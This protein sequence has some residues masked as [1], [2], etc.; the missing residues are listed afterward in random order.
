MPNQKNLERLNKLLEA[1]DSGAVLPEELI[2]AIDA[3]MAIINQNGRTLVDKIV[4]TKKASDSDITNLKSEL[5]KTRDNLQSVINQV[6]SN[7]DTSVV[8]VKTALL[9]EVKR[10][11]AL[12]PVL[13]PETDL[14]G[15]F[16]EITNQR[17]QL[18]QLSILISGE[19]IRNA[20]ESLIGNDRLDKSAIRGLDELIAE[21]KSTT[22]GGTVVGGVRLLKYLADVDVEGITNGQ[23]LVWNSTTNKFEAGSAS[24]ASTFLDLTDTP[25]AYT[26]Q[27]GKTVTVKVDETGVEFTTPAGGGDMLAATYDPAGGAR[28]VA[29]AD[30]LGGTGITRTIASIATPT[31]AGAT[32]SVDYVYFI[33]NTTLTL[34]TAV[35]NTNRYTLKCISGTCV[36]DGDGTETIDGTANITIQVEDSVDLISNNTEWK[37]V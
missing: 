23:T 12:I 16:A 6:K 8:E 10:V 30:E 11:E 5:A 24:G 14:S 33:T 7:S 3:V 28:Q 22:N 31:T 32:A 37:V 25:A 15:V 2:K 17:E 13:P 34:P 29:F 9:R 36:V 18:G 26:G 27:G 35:S 21:L 19:N 1:F 4:E 20:L